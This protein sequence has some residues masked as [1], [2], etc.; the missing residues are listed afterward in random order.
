MLMI[1]TIIFDYGGVITETKRSHCFST[2]ASTRY[3]LE[4][5]LVRRLFQGEPFNQYLRGKISKQ[6]FFTK[7]QEIG[8][9]ADIA[10]MSRQFVSC[11]VPVIKMKILL[12]QLSLAY[13]LC[14]ISDS[15]R[16][17]TRDVRRRFKH[18]FREC[19]FSDEYG[20]VKDDGILY[21]IALSAIGTD[22]TKCLYIDDRKEKLEY[23]RSKGVHSI[24]FENVELLRAELM[25]RYGID[26]NL[27]VD[28]VDNKSTD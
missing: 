27:L 16:E 10:F 5:K 26:E 20:Y 25:S 23:P 7:F 8:V 22:P 4:V 2:W 18:I 3:G 12:E 15:T 21:D 19:I 17:L 28:D 6:Q 14:L 11:N 13:D 1:E 24:H 9:D